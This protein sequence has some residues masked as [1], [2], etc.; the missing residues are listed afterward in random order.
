MKRVGIALLT[1][2]ATG[3]GGSEPTLSSRQQIFGGTP[4]LDDT[5]VVAVVNFAG[6]QCSGSLIAPRLVLTARHCV[7]DTEGKELQV[8]CGETT[9]VPP[10]SPGAIFVVPKPSITEDPADY[11]AVSEIRVP[12]GLG[13]DL[14]GTDV[15]LLRLEA[16][17]LGVTPLEPRIAEPASPGEAYSS[18][19]F[20]VD[21][22]L[23]DQPAGERKRLDA[24][25]VQC[26]GAACR[27]RQVRDNEWAGSQGTCHGDSGGPALD[28]QGRVIGVVSRGANQCESPIFSDVSSR[29]DWLQSEAQLAASDVH[30]A[31][32]S[33][34]PCEAGA[35]CAP[36]ARPATAP[37][38]TC[39]FGRR[40]APGAVWR[41]WA[42]GGLLWLSRWRRVA[43]DARQ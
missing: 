36:T 11:A 43:S 42:L 31:P 12:A 2:A 32:P 16:P 26:A 18:V 38:E 29:A 28:A 15:V 39:G 8:V 22:S 17:L 33:W 20:G 13:D 10:D 34:A 30:E 40:V 35:S 9:F 5:A 27:D 21:E 37:A 6:G 1:L 19:G 41:W 25:Q 3:C 4:D 23:P 7:A 24:L 14:C